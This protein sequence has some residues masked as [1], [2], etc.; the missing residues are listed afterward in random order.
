MQLLPPSQHLPSFTASAPICWPLLFLYHGILNP[1]FTAQYT[2]HKRCS[3][4]CP[5]APFPLSFCSFLPIP[6][7]VLDP[8]DP[9]PTPSLLLCSFIHDPYTLWPKMSPVL[10]E[11]LVWGMSSGYRPKALGLYPHVSIEVWVPPEFLVVRS[12]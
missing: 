7:T 4:P 12:H 9:Q 2:Q 1:R 8:L 6:T 3:R 11:Q 5:L 10:T